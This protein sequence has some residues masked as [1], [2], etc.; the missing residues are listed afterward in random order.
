MY[1]NEI[2]NY[3]LLIL[4]ISIV[5]Y[6]ASD[7]MRILR[8]VADGVKNMNNSIEPIKDGV[9]N[10]NNVMNDNMGNISTAM[11]HVVSILDSTNKIVVAGYEKVCDMTGK[12]E[13]KQ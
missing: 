7:L 11:N 3:S 5:L 4:V 12:K 1:D 13:I 2:L 8:G 6:L 10:I 9:K